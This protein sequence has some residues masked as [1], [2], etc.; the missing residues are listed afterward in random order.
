MLSGLALTVYNYYLRYYF[1]YKTNLKQLN[2]RQPVCCFDLLY[3]LSKEISPIAKTFAAELPFSK[4]YMKH[5][6]GG[7]HSD[8][9]EF[10]VIVSMHILCYITFLSLIN[11]SI[12]LPSSTLF[13]VF[14]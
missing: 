5:G 14:K 12:A 8:R 3:E 4:K 10:A 11:S 13:C 2:N 7:H 1:T 9:F 6:G